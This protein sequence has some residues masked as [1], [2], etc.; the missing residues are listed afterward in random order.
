MRAS[1][2]GGGG[3]SGTSGGALVS[4]AA[5]SEGEKKER[6]ERLLDPEDPEGNGVTNTQYLMTLIKEN[7]KL[8]HLL[9]TSREKEAENR[10]GP[11]TFNGVFEFLCC[12]FVLFF[13]WFRRRRRLPHFFFFIFIIFFGFFLVDTAL[14]HP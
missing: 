6:M 5:R 7:A 1:G 11:A 10:H 8:A 9:K 14:I 12:F 3:A 4:A 13:L 2:G